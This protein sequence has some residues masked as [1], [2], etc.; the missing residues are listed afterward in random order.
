MRWPMLLGVVG[1]W[2]L[3]QSVVGQSPDKAAGARRLTLDD[4]D[5]LTGTWAG[6][7]EY[8]D[9]ADNRT[10]QKL[11]VSFQCKRT[12]GAIEHQFSYVEPNGKKVDG[13]KI[14]LTLDEDGSRLRYNDERW[15]VTD[16]AIDARNGTYEVALTRE[17]TDGD[18]PAEFRRV[19]AFVKGTLTIRTE[20]KPEKADKPFVRNEYVLKKQ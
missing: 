19:L 13:D 7:L 1:V 6:T 2:L 9:Y 11:K 3:G 20:V 15:R 17:G 8:L 4:L 14:K 18:K 16:K 10:K 5:F 12:D